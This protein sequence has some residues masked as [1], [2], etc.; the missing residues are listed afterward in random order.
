MAAPQIEDGFTML[1]NELLEAIYRYRSNAVQKDLLL[2]LIPFTYGFHRK[3]WPLG[4]TFLARET[5]HHKQTVAKEVK[6]LIR[7]RVVVVVKGYSFDRPRTLG[8]QKDYEKWLPMKTHA[9]SKMIDRPES[10]SIQ[11]PI[12][13]VP[14]TPVIQVTE[15][16]AG[17]V[18]EHIKK[19]RNI[20]KDSVGVV[21]SKNQ[22]ETAGIYSVYARQVRAGTQAEAEKRIAHLLTEFP[23]NVLLACIWR[24]SRDGMSPKV[25]TRPFAKTFFSTDGHFR[26]YVGEIDSRKGRKGPYRVYRGDAKEL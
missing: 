6:E 2:V 24:Y 4:I 11:I 13:Q 15:I 3:S 7:A 12:G 9:G 16:P 20:N 22:K 23:S 5:G 1:A 8:L 18:T 17:E 10:E 14:D 26:N 25:R 19:K 21:E